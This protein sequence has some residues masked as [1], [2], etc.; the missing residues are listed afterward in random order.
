MTQ[1][2]HSEA[3][4]AQAHEGDRGAFSSLVRTYGDAAYATALSI[5][6]NRHDAEDV[7]QDAFIRAWTRLGQLRDRRR[8]GQWL[9][10]IVR[11][12]SLE[13]LRVRRRTAFVSDGVDIDDLPNTDQ[14]D[15]NA[16]DLADIIAGLPEAQREAV[17]TYYLNDLTYDGAAAYLDIPVTTLRGRL[18]MARKNLRTVI[19]DSAMEDLAMD[20]DTVTRNVDEAIAHIATEPVH[21]T[22]H[23][24]AEAGSVVVFC[25]MPADLEICHTDG[26]DL[27]ITGTK[28]S[29]GFTLD[30]AQRSLSG[31]FVRVDETQD[32]L[33]D[34]P[35]EGEVPIFPGSDESGTPIAR[36]VPLARRWQETR[37]ERLRGVFPP[38]GAFDGF[39]REHDGEPEEILSSL[40]R[41]TRVTI[42]RDSVDYIV[43]PRA[44]YTGAVKRAFRA[45]NVTDEYA[46]GPCGMVSLVIAV[47]TGVTVT[48]LSDMWFPQTVRAWGLRSDANLIGCHAV[49]LEDIEGAAR[50]W[51]TSL[52]SALSIRGDLSIT[53]YRVGVNAQTDRTMGRMPAGTTLIDGVTGTLNVDVARADVDVR[54][55]IGDTSIRNRFGRA[56]VRVPDA[57]TGRTS[58]ASDSGGILLYMDES[59]LETRDLTLMTVCGDLALD[60]LSER[61][62]R[63]CNYHVAVASTIAAREYPS[64]EQLAAD[65]L[66]R[67]RDGNVTVHVT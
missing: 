16:G 26:D 58:V 38:S 4:V 40:G 10:S 28:S 57:Q 12:R 45:N 33:R 42:A 67:T 11:S 18:R 34:G 56:S 61:L 52:R 53:D 20:S 8:F 30:D 54:N 2:D 29:L 5:V 3:L 31:L 7:M 46:H 1:T 48:V 39:G 64:P 65:V 59:M 47:P 14:R 32:Y 36:G 13:V 41:A 15:S 55:A 21:E 60:N 19:L 24:G 44:A 27:V 66:V 23:V 62:H 50:L 22:H 17:L 63:T 35:G 51:H 25:G 43:L 49:D 37:S 6:G 9:R